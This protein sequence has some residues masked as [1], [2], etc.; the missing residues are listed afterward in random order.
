MFTKTDNQLALALQP[1]GKTSVI[2]LMLLDSFSSH[3][4]VDGF[5]DNGSRS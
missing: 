4:F 2:Q 3:D 5:S 1:V